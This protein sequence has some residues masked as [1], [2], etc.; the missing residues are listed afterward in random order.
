VPTECPNK[1][2]LVASRQAVRAA[3]RRARDSGDTALVRSLRQLDV[4]AEALLRARGELPVRHAEHYWL[5]LR[6]LAQRRP[7]LG[8]ALVDMRPRDVF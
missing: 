3:M 7:E 6:S 1:Q 2:A 8:E 4:A 5:T